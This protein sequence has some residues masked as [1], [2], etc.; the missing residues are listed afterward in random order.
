M[1]HR[2]KSIKKSLKQLILGIQG[3]SR[4]SMLTLLWISSLVLVM[5]SS[6]SVSICDRLLAVAQIPLRRLSPKLPFEESRGHK[7][8]R[9]V[10]M[11]ATKSETSSGQSRGFV[12]NTNHQSPDVIC[13]ADLHD[14]CP[15][16]VR[17][18]VGNL[19]PTLS[20]SRRNGIWAYTSQ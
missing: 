9:H 13:V 1:C 11:F 5:I 19:S 18:F 17:D 8:S 6:M 10:K 7:P 12:A 16:E 20:Q 2:K 3:H 14:L 15:R 4:S